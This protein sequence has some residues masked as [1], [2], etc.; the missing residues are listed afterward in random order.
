MALVVWPT[1]ALFSVAGFG[2]TDGFCFNQRYFIELLPL[3]AVALAWVVESWQPRRLPVLLGALAAAVAG[4]WALVFQGSATV[5]HLAL[6]RVPLALAVLL[7]VAWAM[8]RWGAARGPAG[9]GRVASGWA[10]AALGACLMW[11]AIA[12]LADDLPASRRSRLM[13]VKWT[14][15]L[16]R[17]LP[18]RA[19]V[20][21][22]RGVRNAVVPLLF[23]RDLVILD[24]A[25]DDGASAR[26]LSQIFLDR[27]RRVFVVANAFPE[28]TLGELRRDRA[29]RSMSARGMLIFE[30]AER[31]G[32]EDE[33]KSQG[34]LG[35]GNAGQENAG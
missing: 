33:P 5:R 2:R 28:E 29:V 30:V 8:M 18:P 32:D 27:Q 3:A 17:V 26:E 21:A 9:R 23:D 35:R 4:Y 6:L 12:H 1:L 34:N 20:F 11:S 19:A 25:R 13:A 10:A 22:W 16:D 24:A 31:S 7:L 14:E 15:V